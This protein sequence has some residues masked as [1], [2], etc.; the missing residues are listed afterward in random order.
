MNGTVRLGVPLFLMISGAL[1]LDE[2]KEI[3]LKG[4]L[5]KNVKNLA[6]ITIVWAVIYSVIHNMIIPFLKGTAID[7]QV[8]MDLALYYQLIPA[9]VFVHIPKNDHFSVPIRVMPDSSQRITGGQEI[10]FSLCMEFACNKGEN[11]GIID[12]CLQILAS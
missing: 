5:S 2:R 3:T 6:V 7:P 11:V 8:V 10:L 4:I 12:L 9:N 1:F